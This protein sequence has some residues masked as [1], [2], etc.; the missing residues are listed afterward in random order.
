MLLP[1]NQT[2]VKVQAHQNQI[3][4][5]RIDLIIIDISQYCIIF[6]TDHVSKMKPEAYCEYHFQENAV[7]IK[8]EHSTQS[9]G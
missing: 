8:T 5:W 7:F 1:A 6:C 9:I 2:R 3:H 4:K